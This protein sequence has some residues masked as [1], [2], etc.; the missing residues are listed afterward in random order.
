MKCSN[1]NVNTQYLC[2]ISMHISSH[3]RTIAS[4]SMFVLKSLIFAI[5]RIKMQ[6]QTNQLKKSSNAFLQFSIHSV[7]LICRHLY[8]INL[9]A[10]YQ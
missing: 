9:L 7:L 10:G 3:V 8:S 2:C 5:D 4:F 6:P 1:F